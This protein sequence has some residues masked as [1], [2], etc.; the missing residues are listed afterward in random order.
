MSMTYDAVVRLVGTY[1]QL[2]MLVLFLALV[3]LSLWPRKGRSFERAARIPLDDE[4]SPDALP[5]CRYDKESR[6]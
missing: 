3:G 5:S 4:P 1:G 2:Y 6:Q